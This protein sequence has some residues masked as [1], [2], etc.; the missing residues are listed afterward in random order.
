MIV[1]IGLFDTRNWET[2]K[3]QFLSVETNRKAD[4]GQVN[5]QV[6]VQEQNIMISSM[7]IKS[8]T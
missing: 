6:W 7:E 1:P 2:A 5:S 8:L 4:S 3:D